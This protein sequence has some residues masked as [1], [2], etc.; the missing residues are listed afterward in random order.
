MGKRK[1]GKSK[2]RSYRGKK[3]RSRG[4]KKVPIATLIGALLSVEKIFL[5][6]TPQT[7]DM[8]TAVK[9]QSGITNKAKAAMSVTKNM[10]W[11]A[12]ATPVVGGAVIS[13]V[14]SKVGANKLLSKV[15]VVGKRIKF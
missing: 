15:P 2:R 7:A 12:V 6:K 3:H 14:A 13:I 4:S 1:K 8:M 11:L 10:D 9:A 5:E